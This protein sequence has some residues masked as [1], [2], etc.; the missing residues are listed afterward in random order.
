MNYLQTTAFAILAGV[1]TVFGA[2]AETPPQKAPEM[3]QRY[4]PPSGHA[5]ELPPSNRMLKSE[6]RVLSTSA[7]RQGMRSLPK[8]AAD[9]EQT[10]TVCGSLLDQDQPGIY[11]YDL[12]GN[13]FEPMAISTDLYANANGLVH[14]NNYY[15]FNM[16]FSELGTIWTNIYQYDMDTWVKKATGYGYYRDTPIDLAVDPVSNQVFG[17]FPADNDYNTEHYQWCQYNLKSYS[18]IAI[19]ELDCKFVA[20]G[21]DSKGQFY[22]IDTAGDFYKVD[23][24]SG[25]KTKVGATGLD[26]SPYPQSMTY[27]AVHGDMYLSAELNSNET[28]LW[29][30]DLTTGR[31]TLV[32]MYPDQELL[33]GIYVPAPETDYKAPGTPTGL[34]AAFSNGA[35]TGTLT[36]TMPTVTYDGSSLTGSLDYVVRVDGSEFKKGSAN[37]GAQVSLPLEMTAG[38]HH[39]EVY[40]TNASG[41]GLSADVTVYVGPDTLVAVGNLKAE[42]G[43]GGVEISWTAPT[44]SQNGGWFDPANVTYTV[45]RNQD[46]KT[47]VQGLKD[48]KYTDTE[49]TEEMHAYTYTVTP[50]HG[51]LAGATA[52]TNSVVTGSYCSIPWSEDFS[53]PDTWGMY[54]VHNIHGDKYT[55]VYDENRVCA[56]LDYD[57]NNPKD[58][59]LMSPG[60]K[61]SAD[62]TYKLEFTTRSKWKY[63]ETIEVKMGTGTDVEDMTKTVM[64]PT[65][66]ESDDH[67][68]PDLDFT[69]EFYVAVPTDG[70]YH[71]GFHGMTPEPQY[72]RIE[73]HS[74]SVTEAGLATAPAAPT[75]LSVTP[76]AN[77]ALEA[78]VT[79]NAPATAINETPLTSLDKVEIWVNGELAKTIDKPAP[80]AKISETVATAQGNNTFMVKAYN[81][82]GQGLESKAKA[83]TG[84]VV[85]D[86]VTDV[87]AKITE[88]G[89]VHLSWKAPTKGQDGIGYINP[90]ALTYTIIRNDSSII[91]YQ[92]SGTECTDDLSSFEVGDQRIVS[93]QVFASSAAG[94]SYGMGSNGIVLGEGFHDL[95]YV[96]SFPSAMMVNTPWGIASTT[97]TSW[98]T[99]K[100]GI[101]VASYDGDDGQAVFMPKGP[102]ESSMIYT[103]RFNFSKTVNPT[104]SIWYYNV[105]SDNKID[106][107]WTD[108]Y[109][110]FHPLG[111]IK[112]NES[113]P[114]GWLQFKASLKDL[115]DKPFVAFGLIGTSGQTD[116]QH[117]QYIDLIEV[118]DALDYNLEMREFDAPGA[119]TF[120]H[121][122]IFAGYIT[123]R[124]TK[125][126]E[127]YSIDL[128]CNG[129]KV[130]TCKGESLPVDASAT[131][132]MSFTPSY[133]LA[134][135]ARFQA[136]INWDKDEKSMDNASEERT[137]LITTNEFPTVTDLQ[138]ELDDQG[139]VTLNWSAPAPG[140]TA[141][142]TVESFEDYTA[143]IID[144]IGPWTLQDID[145]ESGTYGIS[146]GGSKVE[147]MNA[148]YPHAWQ[149]WNPAKCGMS[150]DD[151]GLDALMPH[152]GAQSLVSFQ[153]TD[154]QNDDW[155]ISPELS[156]DAQTVT[157]WV[158]TPIPNNGMETFE[159]LYSTTD[160]NIES[161]TKV[162]G[163]K[164]EAFINWEEVAASLP[165]GAKYFAIRHTSA[166][167]Y[168]IAV[169]DITYISK[170]AQQENLVVN[171]YT[172]YRDDQKLASV[173][174]GQT[175]YTDSKANGANHTYAVTVNYTQ[176][177]SGYSNIYSSSTGLDGIAGGQPAAY[178]LKGAIAVRN[179]AGMKVTA[180][181]ADG[182]LAANGT[183]ST[184]TEN[185][186]VQ[187]GVYVVSV[188]DKTFKVV[189]K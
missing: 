153:D 91:G 150:A 36:F 70:I 22:A 77:G 167:K 38:Y 96:E 183:A 43:E 133:E 145:G 64:E 20:V 118:K 73:I 95:P 42:K 7:T 78:L 119:I 131:Y 90:E 157:F 107:C 28:G 41:Q 138:G 189:V 18:K 187:A 21:A 160:Q 3:P 151:I 65:V 58:D 27:D 117:S 79:F 171:G 82:N 6:K 89:T 122:G 14:N 15:S 105:Q 132:K 177:E 67:S 4:L 81:E 176:G 173:D 123:N 124:G 180:V 104:I 144:N 99:T 17:C 128:L 33:L 56:T 170:D 54:T 127:G 103:G 109:G 13:S 178:G 26:V 62:R 184:D 154:G 76:G 53:S 40:A 25:A 168:L 166:G 48:T 63:P 172:I 125:V 163:L 126:A 114:E 69:H 19:C 8:Q 52:V 165:A 34:E 5:T 92:I 111:T 49:T 84:V 156:G 16:E 51:T 155:L 169:D 116:W 86:V 29:T 61:L 159:V 136:V 85:P 75:N 185:I 35:T 55:W 141:S 115:T 50:Y 68:N 71:F 120:G 80:G 186:P 1:C 88:Q 110:D 74:I 45:T 162:E 149:V 72:V 32:N 137:V 175:T 152:S 164:E 57:W 142:R 113:E 102:G 87:T 12:K 59:W 182:K 83:Y 121:E 158:R 39:F 143:Y 46:N 161:F 130:A 11:I 101:V 37:A 174:A 9:K 147:F 140:T 148:T 139:A 60:L 179:A 181:S 93:Y 135:S 31:A 44:E 98:W 97:E 100:D 66:L 112:Y 94:M 30:I 47:L 129:E 134:P 108:N 23:K 2:Q 188:G 106:V 24:H 10:L 146:Y